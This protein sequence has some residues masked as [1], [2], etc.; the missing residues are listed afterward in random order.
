M[1]DVE[2]I[3]S[4]RGVLKEALKA[5]IINEHELKML[6][7]MIDDRNRTSHLY[8]EIMVEKVFSKCKDHYSLMNQIVNKL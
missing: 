6:I 8:N 2:A 3:R 1:E 4:P 7:D 5:Q